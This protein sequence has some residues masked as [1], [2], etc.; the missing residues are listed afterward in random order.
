M[1]VSGMKGCVRMD[2]ARRVCFRKGCVRRGLKGWVEWPVAS[3][4]AD[5]NHAK[6]GIRGHSEDPLDEPGGGG[7]GGGWKGRV[8]GWRGVEGG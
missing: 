8:R 6:Q 5:V 4:L 3:N 7:R 1:S 2:C